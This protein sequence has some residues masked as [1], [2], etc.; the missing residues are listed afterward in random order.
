MALAQGD[1]VIPASMFNAEGRVANLSVGS[2]CPDGVLMGQYGD[3]ANEA[4]IV[5]N[6]G[7]VSG[8]S[9][10]LNPANLRKCTA[11]TGTDL[12]GKGVRL[13]GAAPAF[14]GTV[15]QQFN[16]ELDDTN[17]DGTQV[18]VVVVKA[19]GFIYVAEP[20]NVEAV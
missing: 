18:P 6:S 16:T 20:A 9:Q 13:T 7:N 5:W 14:S 10:Q 19:S 8:D 4:D 15:I 1:T 12:L 17:G 3:T 11:Y 2:L